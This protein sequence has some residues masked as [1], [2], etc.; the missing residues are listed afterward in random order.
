MN[1]GNLC[2]IYWASGLID[3]HLISEEFLWHMNFS[4]MNKLIKMAGDEIQTNNSVT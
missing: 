3:L 1:Q 4:E 2:L